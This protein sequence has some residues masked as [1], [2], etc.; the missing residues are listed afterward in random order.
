VAREFKLWVAGV[1]NVGRLEEGPWKGWDCIGCSL[2]M[3]PEGKEVLQGPCAVSA[4][5]ILYVD[6][7][8]VPSGDRLGPTGGNGPA[9][10]RDPFASKCLRV[11]AFN[12][13]APG[14]GCGTKRDA[15]DLQR[16]GWDMCDGDPSSRIRTLSMT[17]P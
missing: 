3:N 16:S 4:D 17:S 11:I 12:S 1:G 10:K 7:R 8:T 13:T 6:V 2:V 5:T 14:T 15:V 9:L